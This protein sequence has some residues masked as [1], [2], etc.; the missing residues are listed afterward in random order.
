M[1]N[2]TLTIAGVVRDILSQLS[3]GLAYL[4][5]QWQIA[6]LDVKPENI[7]TT[8][9]GIYKLGDLGLACL[10]DRFARNNNYQRCIPP[11]DQ[12]S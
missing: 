9:S 6:H 3:K 7:Y 10:G 5:G 11:S 1:Q 4:H 8:G 2:M 12:N